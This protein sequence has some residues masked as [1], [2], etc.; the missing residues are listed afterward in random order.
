MLGDL[1]RRDVEIVS[2]LKPCERAISSPYHSGRSPHWVKVK[3]LKAPAVTREVEEDWGA[4][5][6]RLGRN[7]VRR[8]FS[9]VRKHR[10]E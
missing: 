6:L 5:T 8:F 4:L 10:A 9:R 1:A 2:L 7:F 3:D